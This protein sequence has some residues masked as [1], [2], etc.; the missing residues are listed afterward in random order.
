MHNERC[1]GDAHLEQMEVLL[2]CVG[3]TIIVETP[4]TLTCGG[5]LGI[6]AAL[7]LPRIQNCDQLMQPL[8]DSDCVRV[9][10]VSV[11]TLNLHGIEAA[12]GRPLGS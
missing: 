3:W 10:A 9:A 1:V 2:G 8:P 6:M 12:S 11:S 5:A 7:R 4:A